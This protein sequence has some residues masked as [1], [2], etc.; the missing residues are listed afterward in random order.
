MLSP[1]QRWVDDTAYKLIGGQR[2]LLR[3]SPRV[4]KSHLARQLEAVLGGSAVLV[5]GASFTEASQA[6][7]RQQIETRLR[8]AI[9][10]HGSVQLIFD[11]YDIAV[12]KSQ[13]AR[14]QTWLNSR[15]I[16]GE[17][18]RDI[19]ALFTARCSTEIQRRGAGSPL[20]SRVTPIYPPILESEEAGLDELASMREWFGESALLAE[21]AHAP[22]RFEPVALAD[23]FEQDLSYLDDVR[24]AS[25]AAIANGY[26]DGDRHSFAARSAAYGLLTKDGTTKLFNRLHSA[27]TASPAD[28]PT[29][30]DDW[31]AS[32][33]KFS[34]LIAGAH[35][36]IWS[37]RFMYRDVE[38]LRAFLKEVTAKVRCKIQL[39][40]GD[41]VSGRSV[42]RAELLRITAVP[43]VEA[44][45][46]TGSDYRDLHDRHL[47][48]GPGGWVVPQVH[49]IVG[50]QA[51]GSTVVAQAASFGV[52]Y[53]A[54]WRRSTTP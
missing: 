30:P 28:D 20:M 21:Q 24:K 9:D 22:E 52:D 18:A 3:L 49:V 10:V 42:S 51:P 46:M 13:G 45:W 37:D 25:A 16:D 41:Q 43:G 27:L 31:R 8:D 4:G 48:T 40:G 7:Q 6:S 44:R 12:A 23:R 54:I 11:S 35:E 39:L 38:S 47:V 29:W 32:I 50:R 53:P 15:L 33:T 17:Y 26:L 34:S 2:L 1:V 36:V 14:L 19:G 5:Q